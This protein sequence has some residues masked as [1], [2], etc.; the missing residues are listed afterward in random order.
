MVK[1]DKLEGMITGDI[2]FTYNKR[3]NTYTDHFSNHLITS[4]KSI[5]I[6][7]E[8]LESNAIDIYLNEYKE[9]IERV[10]NGEFFYDDE[11]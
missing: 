11:D 7:D 10:E 8:E 6:T 1:P 9:A 2:E 3:N 4:V 5:P